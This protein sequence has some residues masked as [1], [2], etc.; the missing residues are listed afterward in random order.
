MNT[1]RPSAAVVRS[2]CRS[3]FDIDGYERSQ[4]RD[5]SHPS[6]KRFLAADI[7]RTMRVFIVGIVLSAALGSE[8]VAQ[9]VGA[10]ESPSTSQH[11]AQSFTV[12]GWALDLRSTVD[13]G[14]NAIQVYA[15]GPV[16]T[17][18]LLGTATRVPRPDI[19]AAY[20][21][22]FVEAE[23]G[24]QFTV[25]GLPAGSYT[26]GV[27][28][29]SSL[30]GAWVGPFAVSVLV[31][32]VPM[33]VIDQQTLG[34][35]PLVLSGLA[36]D[37]QAT[38]S[39]GVSSVHVWAHPTSGAAPMYVGA[40][41]MGLYRPDATSYGP[42]YSHAGWRVAVRGLPPGQYTVYVSAASAYTGLW[43]SAPV[44]GTVAND[45]RM[46]IDAPLNE[47][48]VTQPFAIVGAAADL[49]ASGSTG[50]EAVHVWARPVSGGADVYVGAATYGLPRPD[51]AGYVGGNPQF[52]NVGFRLENISSLSPGVY[53]L[54]VSARSTVAQQWETFVVRVGV[55]LRVATPVL[56]P[57][58]GEHS[59]PVSVSMSTSTPG[60]S[61]HYTTDG[62]EPT[63][64]S[65]VYSAAV[66]ISNA[67][68]GKVKA[69][70][71]GFQPSETVA[72]S[73]SFR[74][75]APVLSP[76]GGI[77][78][79]PVTIAA[80]S[81]T[82]G[83]II[84]Y[85]LDGTDP[86]ES[87]AVLGGSVILYTSVSARVRAFRP[88]WPA[89]P[90]VT[91][92]YSIRPSV[93]RLSVVTG[94]YSVPQTVAMWSDVGGGVIRYTLDGSD[95]T[96]SSQAY[97][98]PFVLENA[99][100]VRA[101]TFEGA[102]SSSD[103]V[104][105]VIS[106]EVA[107]PI[108]APPPGRFN[109]APL[110]VAV[111]SATPGVTIRFTLDG[112]EPTVA[113]PVAAGT[114]GVSQTALL[115]VRAFR[116]GWPASAS[117]GGL[118]EFQ[119]AEPVVVPASGS[120][121]RPVTFTATSDAGSTIRYSWTGADPTEADP[122]WTNVVSPVNGTYSY[123]LRAFR[124]G[125]S[126]SNV[127]S[128]QYFVADVVATSPILSPPPGV[129][130]S[131][132]AVTAQ[133]TDPGS[134]VRY[135]TDGSDPVISSPTY[136]SPLTMLSPT[137][138]RVRAFKNGAAPSS[139][140]GGLY[141]IRV[142]PPDVTPPGGETVYS[143]PPVVSIMHSDP[144]V[145][146]RYTL[147]RREPTSAS[148]LAPSPFVP[149]DFT[150]LKARAFRAGWAPSNTVTHTY[151]VGTG[152]SP[153][154][155]AAVSITAPTREVAQVGDVLR[156]LVSGG[157]IAPGSV[158]LLRNEADIS[159]SAIVTAN[160]I[161]V[162]NFIVAGE[163]RIDFRGTD[164]T[165]AAIGLSA[166]LFGAQVQAV[167]QVRSTRNQPLAGASVVFEETAG[168]VPQQVGVS[169]SS[170]VVR[171]LA[172]A[173]WAGVIRASLA[174]FHQAE[175]AASSG[176]PPTIYLSPVNENFQFGLSDWVGSLPSEMALRAHIEGLSPWVCRANCS[177]AASDAP[178]GPS[179]WGTGGGTNDQDLL[180][181]SWGAPQPV[182]AT[183]VLRPEVGARSVSVRYRF[184]SHTQSSA[185]RVALVSSS[186]ATVQHVYSASQL[187]A[188]GLAT[189]GTTHIQS[190][191]LTLSLPVPAGADVV[192]LR[193]ELPPDAAAGPA[194]T[195]VEVDRM[196]LQG[197]NMSR[198]TL[199]DIVNPSLTNRIE[200]LTFLS[201]G[202]RNLVTGFT[203][204][205]AEVWGQLEFSG[206]AEKRVQQVFLDVMSGTATRVSVPLHPEA[207]ADVLNRAFPASGVLG[208]GAIRRLFA[209]TDAQMTQAA[210]AG[211]ERLRVQVRAVDEAGA[212]VQTV[213]D[214]AYSVTKLT[215]LLGSPHPPR[216]GGRDPFNCTGTGLPVSWP[217]RGDAWARPD[218][219]AIIQAARQALSVPVVD[220]RSGIVLAVNDLSNM[221]GGYFP[222]HTGHR[223]GQNVDARIA[224]YENFDRNTAVDLAAV[225]TELRTAAEARGWRLT[226]LLVHPPDGANGVLFQE[227]GALMVG[228]RPATEYIQFTGDRTH[229][230]HFHAEFS[231]VS[232]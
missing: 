209:F 217:C 188:Q 172:P 222:P 186:G 154:S 159:S 104:A 171:F 216:Y 122:V 114:I 87:S 142:P 125:W 35:Q 118:Y 115:R 204:S 199:V 145:S 219:H 92:T 47:A 163:N 113:S 174:G 229:R 31:H 190:F 28:A 221:N 152:G 134:V 214:G 187:Q 33:V 54:F 144:S 164:A 21:R 17:N 91:A 11:V 201:L 177:G 83:A 62:S 38:G 220:G 131:G 89:S 40:A 140:V 178:G 41:E 74:A 69:F 45:V 98:T 181:G 210:Q 95:P 60:A 106:Y 130:D 143:T 49:A 191:W 180:I 153:V 72:A 124:P 161:T 37:P 158:S 77:H 7:Q 50:V 208:T 9:V 112:S 101:R 76:P 141:E 18:V 189:G 183:R 73:Y 26:L 126:A 225:A 146:V 67:G 82:P 71:A 195:W 194:A 157:T 29:R 116:P 224:G 211:E 203:G 94:T 25:Q 135:T 132:V 30:T 148:P 107:T 65:P 4:L 16:G 19:A 179:S 151:R 84:R 212:T 81:D 198:P 128:R 110:N 196:S 1:V 123:R 119:V 168:S 96:A 173:N 228:N 226:R 184:F 120:Y 86:T 42:Q 160:A 192:E 207:A 139:V 133:A 97:S 59:A 111:H 90:V 15:S 129:Y 205:P 182:V 22:P 88:G 100:T 63:I 117:A 108:Q 51:L 52:L 27:M 103:V 56:S 78:E 68:S 24:F 79:A 46:L 169:D 102:G 80:Q 109:V 206:S 55:D 70:K 6:S 2:L 44:S 13:S 85:T 121:A 43:G 197:I 166:T 150:T 14:I 215:D 48:G 36:G 162:S 127:V 185:Y 149:G 156:I 193:I 61:I 227:L 75:A 155:P 8:A 105:A 10:V 202:Q 213:G 66:P 39:H 136:A 176:T 93:P 147:D 32:A 175:V 230:D 57:P 232:Q 58:P 99:A 3:T 231:R 165:G 20:Q 223:L 23:A 5:G 12:S 34:T 53:D 167:V 64:G 200:P 137:V 170:G 218:V 138:V